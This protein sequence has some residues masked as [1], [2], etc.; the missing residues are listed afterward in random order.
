MRVE[1]VALIKRNPAILDQPLAD[2]GV[3]SDDQLEDAAP[4]MALEHAIANVLHGNGGQGRF[5]RRLPDDAIATHRGEQRVP[6]PHR[7]RKVEGRDHAHDAERL[8]LLDT[9]D[10]RDARSRWS[11]P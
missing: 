10:A 4:A 11:S 6:G 5:E 8:P 2:G 9:C 7:H 1:P 3:V